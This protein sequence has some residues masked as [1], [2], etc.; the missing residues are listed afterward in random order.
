MKNNELVLV[1]TD[2]YEDE[3]DWWVENIYHMIYQQYFD[4]E[5]MH[6]IRDVKYGGV[7]DKLRIFEECKDPNTNYIYFDLDVVITGP[8]EHLFRKE[9]HLLYA[10]WREAFH[11]PLNSSIMS[12]KGDYSFI[13]THF[14]TDP[15]Y[16]M[17]KYDKGIDEFLFREF[18]LERY[19]PVCCSYNYGG[20]N[21]LWS[22]C[23]FNQAAE[24]MREGGEWSE[25]LLSE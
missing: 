6:I 19:E 18:E 7:Y 15:E 5:S 12:W 24:K 22:V 23:L 4:V 13:H 11:T 8:I 10:W 14:A 25:F 9:L 21:K 2:K 1:C 3:K 17:L 20:F 16:F